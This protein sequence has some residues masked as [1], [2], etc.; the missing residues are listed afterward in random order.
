MYQSKGSLIK[1]LNPKSR[2]AEADDSSLKSQEIQSRLKLLLRGNDNFNL[3]K[4]RTLSQDGFAFASR[5]RRVGRFRR[6]VQRRRQRADRPQQ[7][8]AVIVIVASDL[9]RLQRVAAE[10]LG[11]HRSPGP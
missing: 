7:T 10:V 9:L 1:R 3:K 4:F 5:S 2:E 6:V 11:L 8:D